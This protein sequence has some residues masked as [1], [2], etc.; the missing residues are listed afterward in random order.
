MSLPRVKEILILTNEELDKEILNIKKK[1][2]E[3]RLKRGTGQSFKSHL[4]KH[5]RHRLS[6]ILMIKQR[7]LLKNNLE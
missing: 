3:L 2:F 7:R 1:L 4:F 5:N 6:Q